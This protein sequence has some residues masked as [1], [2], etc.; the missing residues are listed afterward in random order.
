MQN[1]SLQE[2]LDG[3]RQDA[4]MCGA[5]QMRE[6]IAEQLGQSVDQ[7]IAQ[8]VRGYWPME[9]GCDPGP[10]IHVE[11]RLASQSNFE[12]PASDRPGTLGAL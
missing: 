3:I 5:Q 9:W 8:N 11:D 1:L 7:T 6:A 4:F 10:F 12:I 2:V